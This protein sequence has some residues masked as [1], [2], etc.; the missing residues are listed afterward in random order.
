[1]GVCRWP[2]PLACP[3]FQLTETT[4]LLF[5][6]HLVVAATY[7]EVVVFVT[8]SYSHIMIGFG[9]VVQKAILNVVFGHPNCNAVRAHVL[10]LCNDTELLQWNV[11]G[12]DCVLACNGVPIQGAHT[13]ISGAKA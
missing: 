8:S 13:D 3:V 1:M 10:H 12:L 2:I 7:Y 4:V 11:G 5:L 9:F 6:T